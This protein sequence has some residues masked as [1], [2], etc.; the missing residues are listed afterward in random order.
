MS[1]VKEIVGI[2]MK[3]DGITENEAW[4]TVE[5]CQEELRDII[6][7]GGSYEA[8]CDC[9]ADWLGLEPD[10]LDYLIF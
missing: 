9:I 7:D 1:G 10:Y 2:L 4:N 5:Q 6:S 3:R 8:A